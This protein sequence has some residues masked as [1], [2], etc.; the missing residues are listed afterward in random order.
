MLQYLQFTSIINLKFTKN[1]IDKL[2]AITICYNNIYSFQYLAQRYIEYEDIYQ[3]YSNF[4]KQYDETGEP[5]EGESSIVKINQYHWSK[6]TEIL[7][8][9]QQQNIGHYIPK[10][11]YLDIFDNLSISNHN[12]DKKGCISMFIATNDETKMRSTEG[13]YI[14]NVMSRPIESV[15]L[16]KGSKC[17]TYFYSKDTSYF[18]DSKR[19]I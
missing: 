15:Y 18:Y 4:V 5:N 6:Y 12:E 13:Y 7:S 9:Y 11:N 10:D 1:I 2:P 16:K 17:F 3:N 14:K 8:E 19:S